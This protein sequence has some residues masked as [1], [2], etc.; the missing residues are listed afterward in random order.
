VEFCDAVQ[1]VIAL[2]DKDVSR[3][4]KGSGK[5]RVAVRHFVYLVL[6][7]APDVPAFSGLPHGR[8]AAGQRD[9]NLHLWSGVVKLE[10]SRTNPTLFQNCDCRADPDALTPM[11]VSYA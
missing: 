9:G 7:P 4:V 5:F 6:A 8:A 3:A 11:C 10:N 2:A 1:N